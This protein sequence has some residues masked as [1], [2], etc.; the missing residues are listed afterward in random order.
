LCECA[1]PTAAGGGFADTARPMHDPIQ[2]LLLYF[3]MPIWFLAGLADYLCHRATDIEHNAGPKESVIHLLMF[4]EF[5]IPILLCLFFEINALVFAVMIISFLAHEATAL[6]DVSYAIKRRYISPLEQHVHSF[7]EMIP[8]M[9]GL[10]IAIQHWGQ[11]LALFGLGPDVARLTLQLKPEPIP[12][13]YVVLVLSSAL[14]LDLLPYLEELWR[15]IR[16]R[17]RSRY[18]SKIW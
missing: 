7:L 13:F 6:W 17:S 3:I 8:L 18:R 10:A 5:A 14:L 4:A 15:G 1:E 16:A 2:A 11:F 12:V 9:A